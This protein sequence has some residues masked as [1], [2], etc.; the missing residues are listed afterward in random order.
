MNK[1]IILTIVLVLLVLLLG[2]ASVYVATQL[3]TRKSVAPTA[4]TSKPS[5]AEVCPTDTG[6]VCS[7]TMIA[8]FSYGPCDK[9]G[10]PGNYCC[11]DGQTIVNGSCTGEVSWVT[12]ANCKIEATASAAI[13]V[14]TGVI[15]CTT[16]EVCPTA[17]GL[18]QSTQTGCTNS[19]RVAVADQ[20]CAA[21]VACP[22]S[23]L[24]G[25]KT[26][27]KNV[28]AN[29]PGVYSLTTEM[30]T[31]SKSQIYVYTIS[32][33]NTSTATASSVVIKD[34]LANMPVTYMDAQSGCSYSAANTEVTCNTT[35]DPAQ[36]KKLSFRVKATDGIANGTVITNLARVTYQDGSL[37]LSKDL[38]VS[39]VV[40]CNHT[41][42]TSE[43]CSTNLTCDTTT[44][45]CRVAACLTED[46]CTCPTVVPA[47]VVTQQ[48][49]VTRVVTT[50]APTAKV[51]AAVTPTILPETGI[52][53][54]PGVAAFGG[55]LILAVVGILLAL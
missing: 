8:N 3:S 9:N 4:P 16:P 45:K 17:C 44:S 38:T 51:T 55:G 22:V 37:D 40:G 23:V 21:T 12:S 24:E 35:I 14:P 13:C 30:T 29:T 6:V 20:I 54:L 11:L 28:T 25:N 7:A 47:R 15:T 52:F 42:T 19:C 43:E 34:S 41:C 18:A 10:I 32:L 33:T 27:Y 53:D 39:T 50:V 31:V 1:K 26:A 5:A 36:I 49:V 48:P 46:D 2:G